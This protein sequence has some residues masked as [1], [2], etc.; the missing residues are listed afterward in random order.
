MFCADLIAAACHARLRADMGRHRMPLAQ[1]LGCGPDTAGA[2]SVAFRLGFTFVEVIAPPRE[3]FIAGEAEL[4]TWAEQPDGVPVYTMPVLDRHGVP[5]DV[6]AFGET[7]RALRFGQAELL[8][9]QALAEAMAADAVE[10]CESPL[11]VHRTPLGWMAAWCR[12]WDAT[13]ETVPLLDGSGWLGL[14]PHRDMGVCLLG[15]KPDAERLLGQVPALAAANAVERAWLIGL[16]ADNRK[17]RR[18]REP[19]LPS[20]WVKKRDPAQVAA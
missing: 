19:A 6:L 3:R 9:A 12:A 15:A 2:A 8:G 20:V 11:S 13:A 16:L 18:A 7:V 10:A 14:Q 1:L 4:P 5:V 17:A